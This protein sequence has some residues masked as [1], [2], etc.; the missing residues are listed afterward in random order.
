M[1]GRHRGSGS[2]HLDRAG[3]EFSLKARKRRRLPSKLA[4]S[5]TRAA[6]RGHSDSARQGAGTAAPGGSPAPTE[7][8]QTHAESGSCGWPSPETCRAPRWPH[9][10]PWDSRVLPLPPILCRVGSWVGPGAGEE[11]EGKGTE[12]E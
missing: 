1:T 6:P 4:A 2:T 12:P 10:H 9:L 3:P 7:A 8:G 5:L 11:H